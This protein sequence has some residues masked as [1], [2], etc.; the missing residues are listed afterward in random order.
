MKKLIG[1]ISFL[2]IFSSFGCGGEKGKEDKEKSEL[3]IAQLNTQSPDADQY[4]LV[5]TSMGNFKL[6]LY[7]ET[8]KHRQNF[9]NLVMNKFYDGQLFYRVI[10][11][12]MIQ[13]GDPHTKNAVPGAQLGEGEVNYKIPAEINPAKYFH[14]RGALSAASLSP[15]RESSGCQFYIITGAKPSDGDLKKY[16]AK[17]NKGNRQMVY[18]SLQ[19]P[20]KDKINQL[21]AESKTSKEKKEELNQMIRMFSSMTDSVMKEKTFAYSKEQ[22]QL[23]KEIGG[24]AHLDGYYTVFGEVIEGMEVIDSISKSPFDVRNRPTQDIVIK[25]MTVIE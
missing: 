18:E 11:N 21:Y 22:R 1:F 10:Q 8:P 15:K 20:Y 13:A 23:Y 25:K 7:R 4:V 12:F 3:V 9:I 2:L 16:E 19:V 14:K 24:A 5:E 17:I 6:K